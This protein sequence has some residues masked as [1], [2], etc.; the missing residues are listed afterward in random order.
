MTKQQTNQAFCEALKQLIVKL[1]VKRGLTLKEA[2]QLT[3]V[4]LYKYRHVGISPMTLSLKS[5]CD[6]LKIDPAWLI[7]LADEVAGER[8]TAERALEILHRWPQVK[9]RFDTAAKM[10]VDETIRELCV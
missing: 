2:S 8:L 7:R 1:P 10:A 3:G 6:A 4:D 9:N 5:Y